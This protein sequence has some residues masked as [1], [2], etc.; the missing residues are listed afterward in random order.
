[1][2]RMCSFRCSLHND[3]FIA[4]SFSQSLCEHV[5]PSFDTRPFP[6]WLFLKVDGVFPKHTVALYDAV[7]TRSCHAGDSQ[8]SY[9]LRML[10]LACNG[11]RLQLVVERI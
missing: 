2:S 8:S 3:R 10:V 4:L 7:D 1:M 9:Q 5:G 11:G 6:V